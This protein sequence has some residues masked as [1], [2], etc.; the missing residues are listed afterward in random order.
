VLA[1]YKVP[2]QIVLSAEP[3]PRTESGK[4]LRRTLR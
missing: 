1:A 2:K 3:L 4:L